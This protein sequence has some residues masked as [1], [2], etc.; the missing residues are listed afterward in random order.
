M[1]IRVV[2]TP[3]SETTKA[4]AAAPAPAAEAQAV[5]QK[6]VAEH[7]D[8]QAETTEASGA[9]E[10]AI[11]SDTSDEEGEE[12]EVEASED[13]PKKN[14]F[15]KR[16]DKLSRARAEALRE[17]DYWR[18]QAMK[19]QSQPA[20][21]KQQEAKRETVIEGKPRPEDF[22]TH[23]AYID[24]LTDWKIEQREKA[25]EAK[26]REEE[27]KN[28]HSQIVDRYL[29]ASEEF[30]KSHDDFD[31]VLEEASGSFAVQNLILKSGENGPEIAYQLAKNQKELSRLNDIK[32]PV[33]LAYEFGKFAASLQ[34]SKAQK[35]EIKTTKAPPPITPVGAN[36]AAIPKKS[37]YD[38]ANLSQAE[39]EELR[40]NQRQKKW[41]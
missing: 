19:G 22:E 41:A 33:D 37:I 23:E 2:S 27:V 7:E 30:K 34:S 3:N 24:R 16:I 13:K 25:A 32:D 29:K 38:A 5:E 26:K 1:T 8:A 15:K 12:R 36:A 28:S 40:R 10:E 14:G 17:R 6:P 18:E 9:L 20:A 39:Y 35:P 4:S 11:E 31:E 21:E